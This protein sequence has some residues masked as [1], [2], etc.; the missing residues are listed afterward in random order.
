[1][2]AQVC[3]HLAQFPELLAVVQAGGDWQGYCEL[4]ALLGCSHK[5]KG[6]GKSF[7]KDGWRV[8]HQGLLFSF[9][10]HRR[11]GS[12]KEGSASPAEPDPSWELEEGAWES[13][14]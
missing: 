5:P 8:D 2:R 11:R 4:V 9:P 1:M 7:A 14:S 6:K 13:G 3:S 10:S 12:H